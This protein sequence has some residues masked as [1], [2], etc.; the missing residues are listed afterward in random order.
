[1]VTIADTGHGMSHETKQ[2][3]F[4][5]FFTTKGINGTGLGLWVSAEIVSKHGG[6]FRIRSR[7]GQG[8]AV[9]IFFPPNHALAESSRV[10]VVETNWLL[11]GISN[12]TNS[13]T[14]PINVDASDLQRN[15]S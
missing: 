6:R 7:D 5:P 14:D 15:S 13:P 11:E 1:M 9:S 4:E 2:H 8:T 3:I 12:N 10:E